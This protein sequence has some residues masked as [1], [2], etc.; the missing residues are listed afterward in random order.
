MLFALDDCDD[1]NLLHRLAAVVDDSGAPWQL[2]S[3]ILAELWPRLP[4]DELLGMVDRINLPS[5]DAEFGSAVASALS[6]A[7]RR[8][9]VDLRSLLDWLGTIDFRD[10]G[11]FG[12]DWQEVVEA[13]AMLAARSDDLDDARW[14]IVARL[15]RGWLERTA[16]LFTWHG[17][18][19][20]ALPLDQRRHLASAILQH[21]P[22]AYTAHHLGRESGLPFDDREWWLSQLA[23]MN[24][25]AGPL[26]D[27]PSRDVT[28]E[29]GAAGQQQKKT[30]VDKAA[31]QFDLQRLIS[32]IDALDWPAITRELRLPVDRHRWAAGAPLTKAPAWVALDVATKAAVIDVAA[33]FL[34]N[35][36]TEPVVDLI[37]A[38]ADAFTTVAIQDP[39]RH[40]GLDPDVLFAWLKP[41]MALPWHDEAVN[42][43]VLQLTE[44]RHDEV[45]ELLLE[46]IGQDSAQPSPLHLRRLGG[47][48]S[49]KLA[50][51]LSALAPVFA[52][53]ISLDEPA[54]SADV[55]VEEVQ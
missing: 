39:S 23:E 12:D 27:G 11:G 8:G 2:R 16:Q 25:A 47:F 32:A 1:P 45:E 48:H 31:A 3:D 30:A 21:Y 50:D 44:T 19:I 49:P 17:S 33:S 13:T 29:A 5:Q 35:L 14:T 40:T 41:I 51:A 6:T 42:A 15:A 53:G 18:D 20:R 54:G 26:L 37:D 28:Q 9:Q 34:S 43:L 46:G 55:D 52:H 22:D 10:S 4:T 7:A 38:A 24:P 36:P